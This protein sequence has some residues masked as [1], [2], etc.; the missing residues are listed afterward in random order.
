MNEEAKARY[1]AVE[2]TKKSVVMPKNK[3]TSV[4]TFKNSTNIPPIMIIT[5]IY[6]TQFPL[7][8]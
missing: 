7:S 8:L 4:V 2:N 1:G 6:E 3:Q 5:R